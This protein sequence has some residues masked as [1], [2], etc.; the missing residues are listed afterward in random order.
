MIDTYPIDLVIEG[1]TSR[2]ETLTLG[3]ERTMRR[4]RS[5]QH[6]E[7]KTHVKWDAAEPALRKVGADLADAALGHLLGRDMEGPLPDE[8][9][10]DTL[11]V[12]AKQPPNSFRIVVRDLVFRLVADIETVRVDWLWRPA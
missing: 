6:T 10:T 7:V 1:F 4:P 9:D 12:T 11:F 8:I 3:T 5:D 2:F